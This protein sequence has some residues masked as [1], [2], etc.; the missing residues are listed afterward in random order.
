[1]LM[2]YSYASIPSGS[3]PSEAV[4]FQIPAYAGLPCTNNCLRAPVLYLFI[5]QLYTMRPLY[6][7]AVAFT[8]FVKEHFKIKPPSHCWVIALYL[9]LVAPSPILPSV[10]SILHTVGFVP[11][12]W[13][14]L[15]PPPGFLEMPGGIFEVLWVIWWAFYC[16]IYYCLLYISSY[17]VDLEKWAWGLNIFL[18]LFPLGPTPGQPPLHVSVAHFSY[19]CN[20]IL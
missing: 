5:P 12:H 11:C 1:M 14:G 2:C 17:L 19:D 10:L 4:L 9:Y 13:F 16:S 15:R 8:M 3:W 20:I 18:I 7:V 6:T